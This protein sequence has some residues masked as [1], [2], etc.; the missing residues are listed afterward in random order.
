MRFI[1][2][3]PDETLDEQFPN[4]GAQEVSDEIRDLLTEEFFGDVQVTP[5][6]YP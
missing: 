1:V 4:A 3:I 2:T 5:Q 6:E